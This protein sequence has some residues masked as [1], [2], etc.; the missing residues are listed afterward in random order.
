MIIITINSTSVDWLDFDFR[1]R[2][3]SFILLYFHIDMFI[4]YYESIRIQPCVVID[5]SSNDSFVG[6]GWFWMV[7]LVILVAGLPMQA[8]RRVCLRLSWAQEQLQRPKHQQQ[9]LTL[10]PPPPTLKVKPTLELIRRSIDVSSPR[11][12][13]D[14]ISP[15]SDLFHV[16][17]I[18][19]PH[20]HSHFSICSYGWIWPSA[21]E[22]QN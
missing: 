11:S 6:F 8:F 21:T 5:P 1:F 20:S 3:P 15:P 18:W 14:S 9:R 22:A 2:F 19:P 16:V 17:Q 7:I 13:C 4:S 10:T 12:P